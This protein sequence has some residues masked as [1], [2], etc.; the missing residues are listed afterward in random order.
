LAPASWFHNHQRHERDERHQHQRRQRAQVSRLR[1][2]NP[3][4]LDK[5]EKRS[6]DCRTLPE[7]VH[8]G[9]RRGIG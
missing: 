1:P 7:K 8:Q 3:E 5:G 6:G 9:Q 2:A 4:E